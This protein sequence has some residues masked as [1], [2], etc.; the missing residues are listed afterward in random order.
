L[1]IELDLPP[2]T[3]RLLKALKELSGLSADG[4]SKL[5]S[6]ILDNGLREQISLEV[7]RVDSDLVF[8]QSS[9]LE[10]IIESDL[11]MDFGDDDPMEGVTEDMLDHDLDIKNPAVEAAAEADPQSYTYLMA[12]GS[13][14][15]R[16]VRRNKSHLKS[17]AKVSM[18]SEE[19]E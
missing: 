2:K 9:T 4:M 12:G 17:K 14:D 5:A 10:E 19:S 8:N 7:S 13:L 1:K 6:S 16:A 3:L 15:P 11:N 18:S